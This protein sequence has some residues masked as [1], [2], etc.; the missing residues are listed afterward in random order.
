MEA[1][2]M[3]YKLYK[4]SVFDLLKLCK[5]NEQGLLVLDKDN[6]M[7]FNSVV[8]LTTDEDCALF[9]QIKLS[10][11][12]PL[13]NEDPNILLHHLVILDF[14]TLYKSKNSDKAAK[15][16]VLFPNGFILRIDN[17]D[18]RMIPFDKSGN[19]GRN[20]RITF[21][22][23]AIREKLNERLNL[24]IDFNKQTAVLSKYYAYRGLY[25][26]TAQRITHKGFKITPE[27]LVIVK[28]G[29]G[30]KYA[31]YVKG[32]STY[33]ADLFIEGEQIKPV[34]KV[35]PKVEQI[36]VPFD[37]QGLISPTYANYVNEV[38]K[39]AHNRKINSFQIR[40]PFAKGMLHGVDFH[41]FISE[42]DSSYTKGEEYEIKDAFD[43]PRD[44]KKAHIIIPQSMF[45]CF[46]WVKAATTANFVEDPM[47]FYCDA[48]DTY[49]HALYVSGTDLPYGK[50]KVTTLSYQALNTLD[51]D[52]SDFDKILKTHIDYIKRPDLYLRDRNGQTE[53]VNSN[54]DS[55]TYSLPNWQRALFANPQFA[56]TKY[57][58]GQLTNI[59]DSLKAQIAVG[60]IVVQG[61]TLYLC[62]DIIRMML[63]LLK[64]GQVIW[65]APPKN[66]NDRVEGKTYA[67]DI[68]L[69]GYRFYLPNKIN[70]LN[71]KSAYG[72][73]RSPHLSRNEQASLEPLVHNDKSSKS[74]NDSVALYENY[75]KDLTGSVLV[76]VQSL[77]PL[78]L[79]GADF[80]GDLVTVITD[81]TVNAAINK[82]HKIN[83]RSWV[84]KL[85]YV[86][87]P[88]VDGLKEE[89]PDVIPYSLVHNTFSNRIGII[90][91]AAIAFGQN[92]YGGQDVPK[93][94]AITKNEELT[95]YAGLEID[96]TKNGKKPAIPDSVLNIEKADYLKFKDEFIKLKSEPYFHINNLTHE[97]ENNVHTFL[98][99]MDKLDDQLYRL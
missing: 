7:V 83:G 32:V 44:L 38:L 50:S 24:G 73:L 46:E 17:V 87:I 52:K 20:F 80:D 33:T 53:D 42:F 35:E 63:C 88:S 6:D 10:L 49:K 4:I 64:D 97:F 75:T 70:N 58:K 29:V 27:T 12:L 13:E 37:G 39:P 16:E 71:F 62:R 82:Y 76:G 8:T 15:A 74:Y 61:Q 99:I 90:S 79:G 86:N 1:F 96:A 68:V 57:I 22:N 5:S 41:G 54:D 26:S 85:P 9:D 43:K 30:T 95:I 89:V 94:I 2:V 25:L 31:P 11:E 21:I 45:K 98:G 18:Y 36:Y 28:D 23:D 19:M 34:F 84:K 60:K 55:K 65:E 66:R 3:L 77:V 51:I 59:S 67:N 56:S 69:F 78:A 72:F 91:N 40:L 81:S 92:N 14:A 47:Q 48:L 93:E